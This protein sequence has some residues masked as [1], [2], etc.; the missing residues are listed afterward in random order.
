MKHIAYLNCTCLLLCHIVYLPP[1]SNKCQYTGHNIL[2]IYTIYIYIYIYIYITFQIIIKTIH[3]LNVKVGNNVQKRHSR[4][5]KDAICKKDY[6][7][8]SK[9]YGIHYSVLINL[10]YFDSV[11]FHIVDR[12]Y[13]LFLGIA[14]KTWKIWKEHIFS[15]QQLVH[16]NMK[17]KDIYISTDVGRIGSKIS[18]NYG[19][20]TA[21]EWKNWTN[22][23]SMYVLSVIYIKI[24]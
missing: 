23:N 19:T 12:M 6:E 16:I 9:K 11:R 14:K 8:L 3:V 17:V 1:L 22:V 20:F 4:K 24:T 10:D 5:L 18:S 13:N 15:K 21:Q 7:K 2:Y